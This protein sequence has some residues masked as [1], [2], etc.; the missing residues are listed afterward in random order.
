VCCSVLAVCCSLLAVC[1]SVLQ[2]FAVRC[3]V[4]H[5][6][7]VY[8]T[9]LQCAAVCCS[10][11]KCVAISIE[12]MRA[13]SNYSWHIQH[14]AVCCSVLAV[15][16]QCFGS[17]LQCVGSVL[18]AC[19]SVLQHF[20]VRC[21]VLQC[22]AVCCSV[23]HYVAVCWQCGYSALQCVAVSMEGIQK[24]CDYEWDI[25]LANPIVCSFQSTMHLKAFEEYWRGIQPLMSHSNQPH[26]SI[27]K[28]ISSS[29][30]PIKKKKAPLNTFHPWMNCPI[31]CILYISWKNDGL[32]KYI[33]HQIHSSNPLNTSNSIHHMNECFSY[34]K[35]RKRLDIRLWGRHDNR[36]IHIHHTISG[37]YIRLSTMHAA[38]Q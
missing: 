33:I 16:W 1:C 26:K 37:V 18:A 27:D 25:P 21:S 4:L 6:V 32:I 12:G 3:S 23:L 15:C 7:A 11:L 8:C 9:T 35:M 2:H 31:K 5:F 19:C 36:W 29:N 14:V 10:V 17:M 13:A 30:C 34:Y 38:S 22:V 20:A 28:Y 24:A